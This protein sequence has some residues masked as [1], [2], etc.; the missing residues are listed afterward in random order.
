MNRPQKRTQQPSRN[1]PCT[2]GSSK[3]Y[4]HCCLRQNQ[5]PAK[6]APSQEIPLSQALQIAISHHR[7]G[8]LQQAEAICLQ[9]LQANPEY[10]DA[11]NLSGVIAYQK[12][13]LDAAALLINKAISL[14][15]SEAD[16]YSKLGLVLRAQHK[17]EAAIACYQQALLIQPG[18]ADTYNNLGVAFIH[19][20]NL[21]AG[22][23]CYRK[24]LAITPDDVNAHINAAE[25]L[26]G[27][28][29]PDIAVEHLRKAIHIKPDSA[30]AYSSLGLAFMDQGKLD[31]SVGCCQKALAIRSNYAEAY[32]NLALVYKK[33]HRLDSAT[34]CYRKALSIK[35]DYADAYIGLGALVMKQGQQKQAFALYEKGLTFNPSHARLHHAL[36]FAASRWCADDGAKVFELSKRFGKQFENGLDSLS[37]RNDAIP[38]KRIRIGYVSGDFRQHSV[39]YFIEPLLASHD[40]QNV[41]TFCYYNYHQIDS[42]T[43]R[44]MG[45]ADHWRSIFGIS[46]QDAAQ[47]IRQDAI[48]I[49]V[50]LSG[51]TAFNRLLLFARKP[52]PVQVTWLGYPSTSGLSAMDYR[53]TNRYV[54]PPGWNDQYHTERLVRLPTSTCFQPEKALPDVNALPALQNGYLTFASFHA[55]NKITPITLS[56]W[57]KLLS[58]LPKA[59][60]VLCPDTYKNQITRQFQALGITPDRLDFFDRQPLQQYLALH[61][62]IDVML[63]TLPYNGGTVSRH[64]LWMGVPVLTLAGRPALSRVGLSLMMQVGLEA[65]VAESDADFVNNACRWA[66]DLDGL[67]QIRG[68]LRERMHNAPFGKLALVVKELE[69]AYRQMWRHWCEQQKTAS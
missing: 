23:E 25:A 43:Q 58:A 16:Y 38:D 39:A 65:F 29:K 36:I 55:A 32:Y 61:N 51:H 13:K 17:L 10:A 67:A 12:G 19:Q 63:D 68:S 27:L 35:P 3:K 9:I 48:D 44:L 42:V 69:A 1:D 21:I 14:N 22:I 4:K 2:C 6:A 46:D 26:R 28:G 5:E 37:H 66:D 50:D 59:K 18:C 8:R 52:A 54:D 56:L 34:E 33:Q 7:A 64:S 57:A 20:D 60:L 40:K 47:L 62:K 53:L 15:P 49:L 30:E 24:A 41:E 11:L 31:A 45:Y